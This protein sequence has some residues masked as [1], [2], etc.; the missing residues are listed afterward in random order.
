MVPSRMG[1]VPVPVGSPAARAGGVWCAGVLLASR[2]LFNLLVRGS[3][4]YCA[5]LLLLPD[6][7]HSN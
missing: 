4:T 1:W 6:N 2:F 5:L 7:I 3:L